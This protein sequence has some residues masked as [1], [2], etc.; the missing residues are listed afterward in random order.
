MSDS[1]SKFL[2]HKSDILTHIRSQELDRDNAELIAKRVFVK[3]H[4]EYKNTI[5]DNYFYDWLKGIADSEIIGYQLESIDQ[6][7]KI[8][9][10]SL[11][12]DP[13]ESDELLQQTKLKILNN[14]DNFDG[15]NLLA[16]AK[17]IMKNTRTDS[18][19]RTTTSSEV[20]EKYIL[21]LI[22]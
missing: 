20:V 17:T 14:I 2:L 19:R 1:K 16:Y 12:F 4:R 10:R 3:A 7:L 6:K 5:G 9:A 11:V 8:H 13:V 22:L 18:L 15:S 21:K